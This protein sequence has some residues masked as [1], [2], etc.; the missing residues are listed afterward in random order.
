MRAVRLRVGD[1]VKILRGQYKGQSGKIE[2]V[3]LKH[4]KVFVAKVEHVKRDGSKTRY[5]IDP[6]NLMITELNTSDKKRFKQKSEV[7]KTEVAKPV[8]K[9]PEQ[10][11]VESKKSESK[12]SDSK[13]NN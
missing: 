2:E 1:T 11:K 9:K 3:D 7:V 10:K 13:I 5:P 12:K 4:T 6:S 8:V